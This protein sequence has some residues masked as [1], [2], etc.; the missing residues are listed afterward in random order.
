MS[1]TSERMGIASGDHVLL[2][3]APRGYLG[4]LWPVPND[5]TVTGDPTNAP[6]DIV[7]VFIS[8]PDGIESVIDRAVE[9]A[10]TSRQLWV[11]LSHPGTDPL[12]NGEFAA[13][14][15]TLRR[16]GWT[17][18]ISLSLNGHWYGIAFTP[19]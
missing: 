11:M 5:V 9:A 1:H 18:T 8:D 12:Q 16:K 17:E 6:F 15:E 3:E 13:G 10:R 7:Q 4:T 14:I 2:L 19:E